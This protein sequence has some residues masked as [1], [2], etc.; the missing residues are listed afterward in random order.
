M[1]TS[2]T[3]TS[4]PLLPPPWCLPCAYFSATWENSPAVGWQRA[5]PLSHSK[6]ATKNTLAA[7]AGNAFLTYY[8]SWTHRFPIR[9]MGIALLSL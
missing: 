2:Q 3:K 1:R 7:L 6:A 8:V 4:S 5:L 9:C